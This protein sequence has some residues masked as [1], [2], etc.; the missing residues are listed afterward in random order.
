[1][2]S[3]NVIGEIDGQSATERRLLEMEM[4]K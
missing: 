2:R 3:G 4:S 1:M